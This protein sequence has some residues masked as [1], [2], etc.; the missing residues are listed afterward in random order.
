MN[1]QRLFDLLPFQAYRYPQKIALAHKVQGQWQSYATHDCLEIIEE[2]SSGL[3]ELG[4]QPGDKVGIMSAVGSPPWTMLDLSLQQIGVIVVP[5]HTSIADTSLHHILQEA[6]L[7]YCFVANED[8]YQRVQNLQAQLPRLQGIYTLQKVNTLP[9]WESLR[10]SPSKGQCEQID[11]RK[12]AIRPDDLATIIYTSGTTGRPK[13]VMLSHRNLVSNI[14]AIISLLPITYFDRTISFLPMSHIFERVAIY[15]YITVGA[16]VYYA[17][18]VDRILDNIAEVKPQYF[19]AVPRLLERMYDSIQEMATAQSPW[20]RRML[21]W[22][23]RLG[24][25]AQANTQTGLGFRLQRQLADLLVYRRWRKVLGGQ[26]KGVIVGAAALQPQ[27]GKLFSVAGIHI[28]EGYGLTETSPAIAFNRFE[29]G[30][31]HFGTVGIPLP[32][33]EV[34]IDAEEGEEGEILVRGPNVMQGYYQQ[35]ERTKEVIDSE[36]WFH[37][38]DVGKMVFK[39][40]LQI[41][42]RKKDIFKTSSGKYVAPQQ[43]ENLLKSSRFIS[44]CMVVGYKRPYVIALIIPNFIHLQR[45]CEANQ[46]HWTSPPYM[47]INPKVEQFYHNLIS[48]LNKELNKEARIRRIHL[49]HEEW[50]VSGGEYAQTLKLRRSFILQKYQK[51]IESLY[52]KKDGLLD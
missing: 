8:L 30:G 42:D 6:E 37:T 46:V 21:V 50:S 36:G 34:R 23:M 16:S 15:T 9:H 4:L 13:G 38:G 20:Q 27:L 10:Q 22:A 2:L 49:L 3:I 14:K 18:S 33:V 44:Q 11:A 28:R 1:F 25:K 31:V 12:A 32:G 29:P 39:R 40:F 52:T 17:E 26:V 47:I 19:T 7:L 24:E 35:P 45:W 48:E 5:L 51:A 43:V 41:T